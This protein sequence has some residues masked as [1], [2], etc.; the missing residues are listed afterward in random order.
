MGNDR[1]ISISIIEIRSYAIKCFILVLI[2]FIGTV[3]MDPKSAMGYTGYPDVL[4]NVY[5]LCNQASTAQAIFSP[6]LANWGAGTSLSPLG[7]AAG[8]IGAN[9]YDDRY[10]NFNPNTFVIPN[11][12]RNVYLPYRPTFYYPYR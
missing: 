9:L 1:N 7:Y 3:S 11:S 5:R 12:F 4:S 10:M 6:F 8:I 2:S